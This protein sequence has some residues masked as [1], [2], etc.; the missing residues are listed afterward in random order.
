MSEIAVLDHD[1]FEE[2]SGGDRELERELAELY[3]K[4]AGKYLAEMVTILERDGDWSGPAHALKG[5]SANLG[6]SEMHELARKAEYSEPDTTLVSQMQ[7]GLERVRAL[8]A[9]RDGA[10]H[11]V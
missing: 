2:V 7:T 1:R 8:F 3:L 4:T 6:I 5:A 9:E 11:A 10:P